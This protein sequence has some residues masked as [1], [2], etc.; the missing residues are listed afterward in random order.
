M[1]KIW[2]NIEKEIGKINVYKTLN[3][4]IGLRLIIL[5]NFQF[6][7]EKIK[8]ELEST[9]RFRIIDKNKN[10]YYA[11][12]IYTQNNNRIF[13]LEIQIWDIKYE[14]SN[15]D[16]HEKYKMGYKEFLEIYNNL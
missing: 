16:S 12:H 11:C 7:I 13:P 10:E 9:E 14:K 4:L 3:D 2:R 5:E 6:K 15:K 1:H 8:K